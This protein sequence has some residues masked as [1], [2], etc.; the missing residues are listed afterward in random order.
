[1]KKFII[2]ILILFITPLTGCFTSKEREKFLKLSD[3]PYN[4]KYSIL[5]ND[6][7]VKDGVSYY[8]PD[9]IKEWLKDNK[10][11][12]IDSVIQFDSEFINNYLYFRARYRLEGEYPDYKRHLVFGYFDLRTCDMQIFYHSKNE[13]Y[14]YY[15]SSFNNYIFYFNDDYSYYFNADGKWTNEFNKIEYDDFL[16]TNNYGFSYLKNGEIHLIKEDFNDLILENYKGAVKGIFENYIYFYDEQ[17]LIINYLDNSIIT[18]EEWRKLNESNKIYEYS[19]KTTEDNIYR[20][21]FIEI[22]KV[23]NKEEKISFDMN[24]LREENEIIKEVENLFNTNL[25]FYRIYEQN[26]ELYLSVGNKESFFGGYS[27][28]CTYPLVFKVNFQNND[29]E[30]IGYSYGVFS[31]DYI[32]VIK[33]NENL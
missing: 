7:Y 8:I 29:L 20:D 18:Y 28:G 25:Q 27:S 22:Y 23:N 1:M 26:N 19:L 10:V 6:S 12:N 30:Y 15:I 9:L 17:P 24:V 31:N 14:E 13:K 16:Y 3:L 4:N 5:T 2:L 11:R 21:D 32:K 33:N